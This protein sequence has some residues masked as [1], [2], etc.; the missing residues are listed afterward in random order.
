[1]RD[2]IQDLEAQ[3]LAENKRIER[4]KSDAALME[5]LA[6]QNQASLERYR[7]TFITLDRERKAFGLEV[8]RQR[9]SSLEALK[10][11]VDDIEE[12][13]TQFA[14]YREAKAHEL[15]AR[16]LKYENANREY[17][18]AKRHYDE[19]EKN[20]QALLNYQQEIEDKFV[21][22]RSLKGQIEK[23][24]NHKNKY[25][26]NEDFKVLL[27]K[28]QLKPY[29]TLTAELTKAVNSLDSAREIFAEKKAAFDR[30]N[31]AAES[32]KSELEKLD[33]T[34]REKILVKL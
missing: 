1:M 23:E 11:K 28:T 22:L 29:K 7:T 8:L 18:A 5:R 6:A 21:E 32:F 13:E 2:R 15:I 34:R 16:R 27:I 9:K 4:L 31:A 20:Y 24:R 3:N 10:N 17:E 25:V 14:E 30:A 33:R 12:V 26:L 19:Q